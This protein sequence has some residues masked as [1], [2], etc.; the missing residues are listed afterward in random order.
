MCVVVRTL[1]VA[2]TAVAADTLPIHAICR[3][4]SPRSQRV[5]PTADQVVGPM[6]DQEVDRA[7]SPWVACPRAAYPMV[8]CPRVAYPNVACPRVPCP[9]VAYPRVVDPW[10]CP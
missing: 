5:G 7:A 2:S 6:T 9:R 10:L 8:A 4:H 1:T 3:S